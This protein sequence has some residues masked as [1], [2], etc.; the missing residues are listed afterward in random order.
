MTDKNDSKAAFCCRLA[1][2][3]EAAG[4][5]PEA[6]AWY[7]LAIIDDALNTQ[8]QEALFRLSSSNLGTDGASRPT[9]GESLS[10]TN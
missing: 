6:R 4:Y 1:S 5:L 10:K 8:A 2:E 7:R 9:V 3:C